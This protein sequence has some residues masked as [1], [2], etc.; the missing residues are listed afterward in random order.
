MEWQPIE[1]RPKGFEQTYLVANAKGQVAPLIRGVIHNTT[2]TPWDW[3]YGES[4]T[5]WMPMPEP[6]NFN[7]TTP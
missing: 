4:V 1:T 6:P 5:N 3:D 2:G 7:L